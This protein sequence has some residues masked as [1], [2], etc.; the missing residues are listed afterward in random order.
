MMR[1]VRR[2]RLAVAALCLAACG[3]VG[4]EDEN[5]LGD[6]YARQLETQLT[7]S[8]DS[9]LVRYVER[10]GHRLVSAAQDSLDR[11]WHFRV[12][13]ADDLNAF[14]LPGGHVYINRGLVARA[15]SMGELAGV[16][17][18]EIAHV[19]RRHS[20]DQMKKQTRTNVIVG[21]FCTLTGWCASDVAQIAI[22]VGGAA[23]FARY[24]RAHESDADSVAVALV[25][26]AGIDPRGV[27]AMF[28][29]LLAERAVRPAALTAFLSS[30]PLEEERVQRTRALAGQWA[31]PDLARLQVDDPEFQ[32][33]RPAAP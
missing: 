24:S 20:V 32:A 12:V 18:H 7:L 26:R 3:T 2:R 11:D 8:A 15:A 27:P 25:H 16:M 4:A 22:N 6:A 17:G 31:E 29:R 13:D 9:A 19:T 14:A 21:L 5:A 1:R 33:V 23:L 28:E 10:L 30:H